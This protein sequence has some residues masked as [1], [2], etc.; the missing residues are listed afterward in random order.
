MVWCLTGS[1]TAGRLEPPPN[2]NYEHSININLP[3]T[4]LST[5]SY[6][7]VNNTIGAT[8]QANLLKPC[9]TATCPSGPAETLTC[10][11]VRYGKTIW[12][13]FYP[14]HDGQIQI[15]MSGFPNVITLYTYNPHNLIPHWRTC[16]PGSSAKSNELSATVRR[17]VAYAFQI[18]GR[19][20]V[21][22]SFRMTFSYAYGS[23]KLAVAPFRTQA[24]FL[25]F[26]KP[27][28]AALTRLQFV[29][30]TRQEQ[31]TYACSACGSGVA[32]SK[33]T[34]GNTVTAVPRS[35]PPVTSATRLIVSATA[36]RQIGRFKVYEPLL[37]ADANND[38]TRVTA[39]GCLAPAAPPVTV[40][41]AQDP[42]SLDQTRCPSP[43]VNLAAAEYT[44]WG[45]DRSR[46]QEEWYS[47]ASW[48][49]PLRI[50]RA[51]ITN[52]PAVAAHP[53]GEQ[54]VFWRGPNGNLWET[55]YTE[56][57]HGPSQPG[58][59][60][61]GSDP[62]A[63]VDSFN[64]EYVFWRGSDYSLRQ[65][66]Y[67][68]GQWSQAI[69]VYPGPL[70]SAPTVAVHADGQL[71]VFWKG[72]D[73]KLSEMT[74]S[75]G[76]WRNPTDLGGG[77]LGSSPSAGVDASGDDYVFWE[78]TDRTLRVMSD[79]HGHWNKARSLH[80]GP[81]DSR[82]EVAVHPDGDLDV[83]WTGSKHR[84]W[85]MRYTGRWH[86]P[87]RIGTGLLKTA[88]GVAFAAVGKASG[89]K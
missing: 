56:K 8:D 39:E 87:T 54:D 19:R 67:A 20:G 33:T 15:R 7:N 9:Y 69:S 55:W 63:G 81:L 73:G 50:P 28:T 26:G 88:P 12:Y 18:G 72:T 51:V 60:H 17:G 89:G 23:T 6:V 71:D 27:G 34:A 32:G 61:L 66:T 43:R 4:P 25:P 41:A 64:D 52:Q 3:R 44:F 75:G 13:D 35:A 62:T 16:E 48:I 5:N 58:H 80:S 68:D 1:S 38:A 84:L 30:V 14:D 65:M 83:F 29:G 11:G 82:P 40:A 47:G 31:V 22:N 86:A 36:P 2:D 53:N 77:Q 78:G 79:S 10:R 57:W 70:A 24:F 42:A 37:A 59:T 76:Q 85:E 45:G 21:G 49:G 74:F 46:L